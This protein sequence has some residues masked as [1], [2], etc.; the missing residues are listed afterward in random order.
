LSSTTGFGELETAGAEVASG[1][2]AGF[3]HIIVAK[4][5][6]TM[7]KA[8][9]GTLGLIDSQLAA[10]RLKSQWNNAVCIR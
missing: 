5:K 3:V 2:R 4:A 1:A 8:T 9:N 6:V 10:C 7:L